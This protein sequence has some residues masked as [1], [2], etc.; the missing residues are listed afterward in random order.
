MIIFK[1]IKYKNFLSTGDYFNEIDLRS[2]KTTLISGKNGHGKSTLLCAINFALFGKPHRNIRK[3]QLINSINNKNC[4]VELDFSIGPNEYK[5]IR[6]IK[7]NI[8]EIHHNGKL[9]NQESHNRDYQKILEMNILKMNYRSFNQVV[10]L[11]SGNF[12]PFMQLPTQ[13]RRVIIEELLDI[14]IF[15][16]MNTLLKEKISKLKS[17]ITDVDYQIK[18]HEEQI[19]MLTEHI[20]EINTI[21]RKDVL[22]RS[23]KIEDLESE[24]ALL[25][26]RNEEL[27]QECN[28]MSPQIKNRLSELTKL[29]R[30]LD[31]YYHKIENNIKSKE[32]QKCFFHDNDNCPTCKQVIDEETKK[33][34]IATYEEKILELKDALSKLEHKNSENEKLLEEALQSQKEVDT[35]LADVRT[36]QKIIANIDKNIKELNDENLVKTDNVKDK[37][38]D[39][40]AKKNDLL[41]LKS[42][43]GEY[44]EAGLYQTAI[45]EMLK[46]TGIKTKIIKQYL[47]VMNKMINGY[48]NVLDF[49]VKFELNENFEEIIKSRHL[50]DFSYASFSEGE[51]TRIDLSL[52]FAWRKIASMKNSINCNLLILDEIFSSALDQEGTELLFKILNTLGENTNTFII[53][54]SDIVKSSSNFDHKIEFKKINNFS[55]KK[56][57]IS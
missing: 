25:I 27:V 37:E 52:L 3:P 34:H 21:N 18:I 29:K 43:R 10:I 12:I 38:N 4:I 40:L 13:A 6:G 42:L 33:E 39:L 14:N 15:S 47:P 20:N 45:Q 1:T 2:H 49:F 55:Y 51:K 26:K 9:M 35:M 23:K 31:S 7:P 19:K 8:F 41:D 22:N 5:I 57:S 17:N 11:G 53:S 56:E 48:L 44:I 54:H 46:D 32:N 16:K 28:D 50:D 24:K 30:T 36:N